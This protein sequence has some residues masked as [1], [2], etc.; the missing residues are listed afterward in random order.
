[1]GK[2]HLAA[3]IIEHAGPSHLMG[4]KETTRAE[5]AA[6]FIEY[7]DF[8]TP[9]MSGS[10]IDSTKNETTAAITPATT[11]TNGETDEKQVKADGKSETTTNPENAPKETKTT[12]DQDDDLHSEFV[13]SILRTMAWQLSEDDKKYEKFLTDHIKATEENCKAGT[14]DIDV[15]NLLSISS[16]PSSH[17]VC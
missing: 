9:T 1:V 10:K 14:P 4:A 17:I 7:E 11:S 16:S 5:V 12:D 2:S 3:K 8:D 15:R 6:Y 13:A